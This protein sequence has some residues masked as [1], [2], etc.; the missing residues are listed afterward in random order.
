MGIDQ[1]AIDESFVQIGL[2]HLIDNQIMVPL[3]ERA[4]E[5]MEKAWAS[6]DST[7]SGQANSDDLRQSFD[8]RK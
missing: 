1:S 4:N 3:S 2:H 5:I 6:A 8:M 7:G